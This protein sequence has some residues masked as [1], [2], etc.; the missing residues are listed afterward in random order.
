MLDRLTRPV[1]LIHPAPAQT[2]HPV[3]IHK[4]SAGEHAAGFAHM[5]Q[6]NLGHSLASYVPGLSTTLL[7]H[8]GNFQACRHCRKF[9][10]LK[11][12]SQV[13]HCAT[14]S[15]SFLHV[16]LC[17]ISSY[18]SDAPVWGA[19]TYGFVLKSVLL[20]PEPT[21]W[22]RFNIAWEK[23]PSHNILPM[24]FHTAAVNTNIMAV[25]ENPLSLKTN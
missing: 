12:H 4:P 3:H 17:L 25:Q 1:F 18:L 20:Y 13:S 7:L 10:S 21:V 23:I 22:E 8:S 5:Q 16:I 14:C 24:Y 9:A 6:K 19:V 2:M 15:F 11:E